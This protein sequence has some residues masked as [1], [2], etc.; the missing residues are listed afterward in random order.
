MK[1]TDAQRKEINAAIQNATTGVLAKTGAS[2]GFALFPIY[3]LPKGPIINGIVARN[4]KELGLD[5]K[6]IFTQQL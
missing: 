4:L 3:K 5:Q 6:K 2:N 1:L